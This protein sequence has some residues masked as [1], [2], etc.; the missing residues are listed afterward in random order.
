MVSPKGIAVLLFIF[1]RLTAVGQSTVADSLEQKLASSAGK[2]RVDILNQLTFEFISVD[3]DKVIRYNEEAIQLAKKTGYNKGEG[4]AHTYRGL[5]LYQSGQFPEARISLHTGLRLSQQ[6]GDKVNEGYTYLQLGNAGLEEVNMD[7][8]YIYFR[9]AYRIFKDSNEAENLSKVYRN[10]SALFGQRFQPDSQQYYLDKAIVIRRLLPDQSYLVDALAIQANNKL[11]TGNL[12]EAETLLNEADQILSRYPNDLENLNDVKHIRALVLFQKGEFENAVVLFDSARNYYFRMSLFRKYVTLLT[13]LARIFSDRGEYELALNNLYDALRLSIL[14]GFKTETYIIRTRIGWVN[15]H[16]GDYEQALRLANETQRARPE[17]LLKADLANALTLKGVSLTILNDLTGARAA[18]DTVLMLHERA[19]NKQ[20]VSEAYMNLG[21]VEARLNNFAS[22]LLLY[23]KSITLAESSNYIYGLA[24]SNWGIADIFY[25]QHEY[26]KASG[27]LDESEKFSRLIHA[28]ELLVASYKTRRDILRATGRFKEAL[29]FSM[30][31]GQ[32]SDSL[33]RSDLAR[34]FVNLEK[35]QAIE[36]RDRNI[37]ELQQGKELAEDKIRLQELRLRQQYILIVA[38]V[39]IIGLLAFFYLRIKKL[40]VTITEKNNDIQENTLKLLDVNQELNRLYNEVSE[41]NEEIQSQA[42]VLSESNRNIA[43]LN[44]SLERLIADKTEELRRTNEELVKHN[45]ELLQFSYTV[46]H[47]LRGPVARLLGLTTL[48]NIEKDLTQAR[49][50]VDLIGK[51]TGELD[52]I[53]KDLGKILELRREPHHFRDSVNLAADWERSVHLLHDSLT[54]REKIT[55]DFQALPELVTVRAMVQSVF[56]NL[57]SNA[58]KFRSPDR[59]LRIHASSQVSGDNAIITVSD[60]GL[61]FD[62]A[63][64][65]DKLFRL[66]TR[67]HS[68]VEGRGLGLYLV[69]TQLEVVHGSIDVES[70][71]REGTTFSVTIPLTIRN[72]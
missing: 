43:E 26:A 6:A 27:H 24:W 44:R 3:N 19:G 71:P 32:M 59:P 10:M 66:Y 28:N 65:K 56:Y 47:N 45:N 33:R 58:L 23:R 52:L 5:Y 63:L 29:Q 72:S 14:K 9:K 31:A 37:K 12:H 53:I 20:G 18:L 55:A 15:F 8:S 11:S 49:Q 50:W 13:D 48:M 46:S 7:S 34:R 39:L 61:G 69:K 2:E 60:N 38:G 30:M 67:F 4:V 1:L 68:H 70:T 41:Q 25:R 17:K 40:N 57:L 51:T 62:T 21:V 16:L 64:Y 35:I 54:G 22:A 36:Q 42:Q